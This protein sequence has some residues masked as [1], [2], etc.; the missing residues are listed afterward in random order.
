MSLKM[1]T[2]G[3]LMYRPGKTACD[4]D[5][6]WKIEKQFQSAQNTTCAEVSKAMSWAFL[7]WLMESQSC[8]NNPVSCC[9]NSFSLEFRWKSCFGMIAQN[10]RT[11]LAIGQLDI[12][13]R[14]IRQMKPYWMNGR[15]RSVTCC[16][17]ENYRWIWCRS[18]MWITVLKF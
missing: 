2:V 3:Q 1:P 13:V 18:T 4:Q 17:F 12:G 11:N 10:W 7:I 5:G 9:I 15:A 8:R 16:A 14:C 6:S